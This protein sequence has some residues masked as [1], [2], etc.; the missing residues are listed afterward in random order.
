MKCK[1]PEQTYIVGCSLNVNAYSLFDSKYNKDFTTFLYSK[2][3][4]IVVMVIFYYHDYRERH[5]QC[6]TYRL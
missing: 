3:S 5:Y 6:H 1:F 4:R 2:Y